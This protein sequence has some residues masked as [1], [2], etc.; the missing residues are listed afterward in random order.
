MYLHTHSLCI[1]HL[2]HVHTAYSCPQSSLLVRYS[3]THSL[4]IT[5]LSHVLM[6]TQPVYYLCI[7]HLRH[8]CIAHSCTHSLL[9]YTLWSL[10]ALQS[11]GT[12]GRPEIP[13]AGSSEKQTHVHP[14]SR[15]KCHLHQDHVLDAGSSGQCGSIRPDNRDGVGLDF[16]DAALMYYSGMW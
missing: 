10:L 11:A 16:L 5:H 1:T 15:R 9:M 7:T 13:G 3:C 4:C 12:S 14:P 8:A 2:S 6:Y